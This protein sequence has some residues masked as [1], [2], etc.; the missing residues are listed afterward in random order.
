MQNGKN[1]FKEVPIMKENIIYFDLAK[2]NSDLTVYLKIESEKNGIE[3]TELEKEEFD[4]EWHRN[5]VLRYKFPKGRLKN[6]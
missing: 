6:E 1:M 3:I 2:T 5:I 4:A